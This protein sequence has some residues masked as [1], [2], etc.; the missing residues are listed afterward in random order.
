MNLKRE[1]R[2]PAQR[3]DDW[4]SHR[5]VGDEMAIHDIDVDP[6]RSGL[7]RFLHLLT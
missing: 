3:L 2:D 7:F 1:A 6:I 5:K 4:C